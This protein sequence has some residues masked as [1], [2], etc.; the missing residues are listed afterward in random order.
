MRRAIQRLVRQTTECAYFITEYRKFW[1]HAVISLPAQRAVHG[2]LSNVDAMIHAYEASFGELK[3]DF[4]MGCILLAELMTVRVLAK[5]QN[6]CM[7]SFL[8]RRHPS[9]S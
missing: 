6:I 5:A 3:I 9:Q 7:C 1:N 4:M 2:L 8:Q